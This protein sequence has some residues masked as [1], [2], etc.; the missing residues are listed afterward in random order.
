MINKTDKT[1]KLKGTKAEVLESL[2]NKSFNIPK[3]YYFNVREWRNDPKIIIDKII[4]LFSNKIVAVRSSALAEDTEESSMAGAFKSFLNIEVEEKTLIRYI[5]KVISSFDSNMLNQVLIQ[6][7][8]SNVAM[9]GVIMSK[10]LD[11]GSPYYVINYDDQ[12]G[13]T[14]TVTSGSAINK[15]VYIYNGVNKKDF[16]SPYLI[17]ALNLVRNLEKIFPKIPLDIEFI[18]DNDIKSFLLQVR[19][20]TTKDKWKQDV[21]SQ[22]S[23]RMIFLKQYVEKIMNPRSQLF[24][25]KTNFVRSDAR[26]ESCRDDW[27]SSSPSIYVPLQSI[28]YQKYLDDSKRKNGI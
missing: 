6:P 5:N 24:G 16:D 20:I 4:K 8:V 1:L 19:R 25:E 21:N 18:I 28:D 10:V 11:D 27:S 7:M 23:Q 2:S 13:L 14:D 15:T 26:L 3:V 12:T 9:S 17:S 22:V